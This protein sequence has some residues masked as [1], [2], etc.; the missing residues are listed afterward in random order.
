M[1]NASSFNNVTT[2]T[3]KLE[4]ID[5]NEEYLNISDTT[6]Q[7]NIKSKASWIDKANK[8][9]RYVAT[10]FPPLNFNH[11]GK[12]WPIKTNIHDK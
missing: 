5:D 7:V 6:T 10:P 4:N 9:P 12:T 2:K 8:T 11:T 1:L 3:V